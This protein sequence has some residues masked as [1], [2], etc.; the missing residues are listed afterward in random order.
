MGGPILSK[1][2][3]YATGLYQRDTGDPTA[4]LAKKTTRY[5]AQEF[6]AVKLQVGLGVEQDAQVT[7][8]LGEAIGAKAALMID[9]N[10]PTTA[11]RLPRCDLCA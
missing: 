6:A 2:M 1:M 3:A 9:A 5:C 8:A 10:A 11:W 7:H 4:Y